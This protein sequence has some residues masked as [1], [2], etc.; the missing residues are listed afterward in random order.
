MHSFDVDAIDVEHG[1]KS[2]GPKPIWGV[3][4]LARF[5]AGLPR[6]Q[7]GGIQ[8]IGPSGTGSR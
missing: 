6:D 5:T 4:E 2:G 7:M 3:R 8:G 1:A